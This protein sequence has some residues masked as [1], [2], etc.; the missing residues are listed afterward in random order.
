MYVSTACT[1]V[2][3]AIQK[4]LPQTVRTELRA[5]HVALELLQAIGWPPR[6]FRRYRSRLKRL[7]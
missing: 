4:V 1:V 2:A 5:C 3:D 6:D 7:I